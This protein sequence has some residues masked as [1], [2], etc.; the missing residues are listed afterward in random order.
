MTT[1]CRAHLCSD[2]GLDE[3]Q[4]RQARLR[5]HPA[6]EASAM[7][8][9]VEGPSDLAAARSRGLPAVAISGERGWGPECAGLLAGRFVTVLM[10]AHPAGRATARR[11]A[12][13][14]DS[15]AAAV[16]VGDL[17]PGREDGYT[18]NQWLADHSKLSDR[19]L[20]Y[21]MAPTPDALTAA[22]VKAS[23]E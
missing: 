2:Q 15:V 22:P 17:A 4:L 1:S 13:D 18:L 8:I 19:A 23:D 12:E 7:I 6:T 10:S 16:S 9:L 14:L 3:R 5:P 20:R 21:L 11:I